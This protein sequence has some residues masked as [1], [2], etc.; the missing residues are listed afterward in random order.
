MIRRLVP[1]LV[2]PVVVALCFVGTQRA[3]RPPSLTSPADGYLPVDGAASFLATTGQRTG[4]SGPSFF[5]VEQGVVPGA[6][7]ALSLTDAGF[8]AAGLSAD[9]PRLERRWLRA[10][11]N[12]VAGGTTTETLSFVAATDGLA[13]ALDELASGYAAYRPALPVLTADLLSGRPVRWSG[14][15]VEADV[16]RAASAT[17]TSVPSELPGCRETRTDLRFAESAAGAEPFTQILTFCSGGGFAGLEVIRD[18][19]RYGARLTTDRPALGDVGTTTATPSWPAPARPTRTE[20]GFGALVGGLSPIGLEGS[21]LVA[22]RSDVVI[23]TSTGD[24]A[25]STY[26]SS[27]RAYGIFWRARPGGDVVAL[28]AAGQVSV[29]A[30]SQKAVLGYDFDGVRR[31]RVPLPDLAVGVSPTPYGVLVTVADGTV[32]MLDPATGLVRWR[33]DVGQDAVGRAAVSGDTVVVL[34]GDTGLHALDARTGAT[35][36][37]TDRTD[38][39]RLGVAGGTVVSYDL[40]T[41]TWDGWSLADGRRRW[42][43]DVPGALYTFGTS[44]DRLVISAEDGLTALDPDGRVAWR[45]P[46]RGALATSG[47][48]LASCDLT[49]CEL[50]D[51]ATGAVQASWD[52]DLEL[53]NAPTV[54]FTDR[55]LL[56]ALTPL[57]GSLTYRELR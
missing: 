56:L 29:A 40:E 35:R 42:S 11:V 2:V 31:W 21:L 38:G 51:G 50:R 16:S 5:A 33:T 55:G 34:D 10:S 8:L 19:T 30:T 48:R 52:L 36:W 17:I 6:D 23:A 43:V 54:V 47:G 7:L 18:G 24:L 25:L 1:W 22:A 53:L 45:A 28:A 44:G 57:H 37:T 27:A 13:L 41:T 12:D 4:R 46:V 49:V 20:V 32:V 3:L 14:T 9:D 15:R 39:V 26:L